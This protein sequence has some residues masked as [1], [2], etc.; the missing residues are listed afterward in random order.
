MRKIELLAPAGNK[1][2]AK[3]AILHGA[4]A[5]YMGASSHGARKNASN[6][7]E[8]IAEVVRFAHQYRVRVYVTVNT[9]VYDDEIEAVERL[10]GELYRAGV[11]ALIVQDMGVLKMNIPPICLHA[12]TQCDTRSAEKAREL[13][14]V[15]FSQIVLARELSL[16]EISEIYRHVQVPLEAFVHGALCVSYS[17]LCRASQVKTGRSANR[18]ECSQMCRL[19]YTLRDAEGRKIVGDKYLLSLKDFNASGSIG[20]MIEAGV[21]S[22]KIEGRLKDAGYVKNIVAYYRQKIDEVI[23]ECPERYCRSSCGESEISFVPDPAKSF[24]RGFTSYFLEGRRDEARMSSWFTPKSVGERIEDVGELRNGDGI[25]FMN[26][27]GEYEG[28]RVNS[29]D[30]GRIQGARPFVLPKGAEIRR[31]YNREWESELGKVTGRRRLFLDISIDETGVTARDERG[32]KVRVP[33]DVEKSV[34]QKPLR[35]EGILGKLGNTIY[36]LR[37][38]E[39]NLLSTTFIP[40]S[41]LSGIKRRMLDALDDCGRSRYEFEMRRGMTSGKAFYSGE[42]LNGDWNV[43]NRLAREFYEERGG[44]VV[45]EAVEVS[46]R[47]DVGMV[48]MRTRYC[49]RREMGLCKKTHP[50]AAGRLKEPLFIESGP[51]RFRLRFDCR[52]CEMEVLTD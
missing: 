1:E 21:S 20:T 36:R 5:V 52:N 23:S 44:R 29:V 10:I 22:F 47:R 24:N 39:N 34:A 14:S 19:P 13:E 18:G 50:E 7:V 2:I 40:A 11:D 15:G 17:G 27:R 9:L 16:G 48:V 41:Q 6:S 25:S 43:A 37:G 49:V 4:D 28:V 38:F 33:L 8:D 45:E 35:P 3:E 26:S 30:K 46:G 51:N 31:T 42:C 32:V 12:S